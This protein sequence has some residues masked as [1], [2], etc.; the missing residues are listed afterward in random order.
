MNTSVKI[1]DDTITEMFINEMGI[2]EVFIGD[3]PIYTRQ[4]GFFYLELNTEE[5]R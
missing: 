1:E 3:T 2:K 4:G 5:S